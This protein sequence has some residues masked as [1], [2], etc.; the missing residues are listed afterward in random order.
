MIIRSCVLLS[1]FVMF[2]CTSTVAPPTM[3]HY[4]LDTAAN[5]SSSSMTSKSIIKPG[6]VNEGVRIEVVSLPDYL[7][8][9]SLV[10][11][12][13]EHKME[14]ARFHSWADRMDE[15]I[16]SVTEYETNRILLEGNIESV[17]KLCYDLR[18]SI[19]HFYPT[20]QGDV[21]LTGYFEYTDALE[22]VKRARFNL[23]DEMLE[24]GY[25]EAV[26]TMRR[27][28]VSL[29]EELA[30]HVAASSQNPT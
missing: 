12:V 6:D 4:L 22:N 23:R 9:S 8:Q 25:Q 14:V 28:L 3:Q 20:S 29:S 11:L 7:N 17:C 26:K 15:S 27:M 30:K 16:E 21:F 18:L 13:D 10:M 5:H 19:E 1:A 2:S 24:D